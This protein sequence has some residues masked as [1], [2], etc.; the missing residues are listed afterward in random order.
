MGSFATDHRARP[1]HV[2]HGLDHGTARRLPDSQN[3]QCA[4]TWHGTSKS[5]AASC[6]ESEGDS[7]CP[8]QTVDL[9]ETDTPPGKNHA[10]ARQDE[11][12][13][14]Q[15]TPEPRKRGWTARHQG[16][17]AERADRSV[18]PTCS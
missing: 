1:A 17:R 11:R 10:G 14:P 18:E 6:E 5:I 2:P 3:C 12:L 15:E 8:S 16:A 7:T 13:P 9:S 4:A